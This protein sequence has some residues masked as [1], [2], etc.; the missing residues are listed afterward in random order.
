[1][2]LSID[3]AMAINVRVNVDVLRSAVELVRRAR[4]V[5]WLEKAGQ[6]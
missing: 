3:G 2:T 6:S 5:L 1:M 4:F